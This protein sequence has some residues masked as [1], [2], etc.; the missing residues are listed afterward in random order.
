MARR[1]LT[2]SQKN[3]TVP[4][5]YHVIEETIKEFDQKLQKAQQEGHEGRRVKEGTWKI[6]QLHHQK[7]RF[8]Y[9]SYYLKHTISRQLYEYCLAKPNPIA[10]ALLIGK[11][12]KTGYERL[13]C[14]RCIQ[15]QDTDYGTTCV[16]RIPASQ[17]TFTHPIECASCGCT[18]CASGS[19]SNSSSE[20][21]N[22][23]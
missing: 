21:T 13:C 6:F 18:G 5:D 7:S 11:W 1:I 10:D 22:K 15:T 16:C 12:K 20:I 2:N 3:T 4:S 8:I 23:E 17:I 14:L 9:E 19:S